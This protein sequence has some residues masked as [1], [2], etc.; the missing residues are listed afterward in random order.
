ME[1]STVTEPEGEDFN[2]R[3]LAKIGK[4][5]LTRY[6]GVIRECEVVL[7]SPEVK[8][9][10]A[11][12][13]NSFQGNLY[14]I[15]AK[16][17]H[18][19]PGEVLNQVYLV[20]RQ[21]IAKCTALVEQEITTVQK[22]LADRGRAYQM[23]YADA[24]IAVVA[25]LISGYGRLYLEL[26]QKADQLMVM[27]DTLATV[28]PASRNRCETRKRQLKREIQ[29]IAGRVQAWQEELKRVRTA[30]DHARWPSGLRRAADAACLMPI[31]EGS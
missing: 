14:I 25:I 10:Y 3:I 27:L 17:W 23:T 13:F 21:R 1:N 4:A 29:Q 24:P 22:L 8:R 19:F 16:A 7:H 5:Q 9:I 12:R 28:D 2:T 26:L 6:E 30:Q 20:I 11:R 31:K 15:H 18:Q